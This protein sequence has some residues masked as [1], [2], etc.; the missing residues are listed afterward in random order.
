MELHDMIVL[1]YKQAPLSVVKISS[2]G[3]YIVVRYID[4]CAGCST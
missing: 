1:D 2:D 3:L 4:C